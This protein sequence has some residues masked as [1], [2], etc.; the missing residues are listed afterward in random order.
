[1]KN[2]S[3]GKSLLVLLI[4]ATLTHCLDA[5][6]QACQPSGKI[7]GIK[8][9]PGQ[10][11]PENDSDCCKQGKMYTTYK[12]SPP[13]TGNT[14][15]VLTLNSFQKGGDGGGP[16]ECDNQYHSDDTPVVALSTGWYSGGD[17]CL[18][19]ITVSA[20]G[21][22]VKAKVV[23]EC[24]STMGCDDEHDYQ[25]PC[26]NNI[27]DASKA[28]WEALER[29][30]AYVREGNEQVLEAAE[31]VIRNKQDS[32]SQLQAAV[33][34]VVLDRFGIAAGGDGGGPSEYDNQYHSDDTP[35]VALSTGWYSGGD[36]CLN[37]ITV[38][39][40]G[41]SV[42]AKVVDECDSTMGCDDEY[43][44]Q[45]PCPNNI[46]DA[47]KAVW[48]A[49]G[50]PEVGASQ[51]PHN[52][53]VKTKQDKNKNHEENSIV[54][55]SLRV[56][57]VFVTLTYC[58]DARLQAC[59]PSGKIRG[60]K[61]P[62]GQCNPENDSDCCKQEKMYTT[63]K[64][65][66]P[67][68]SNTKAVLTLNSFQAGGDGG[69][70]SEC[71]NQYHS[72]DTP[73]VAHSTGWYSGGDRCL[74]YITASADGRSVKAKVVDECDSTMGCDDEHD[75]QPPCP[76]NIVDA[77]K[78]VWEALHIPEVRRW[79][80]LL[81]LRTTCLQNFVTEVCQPS[82]KIRGIKPPPG[83]CN[84]ENDSDCCKQ[85]KM[86][87]TYQCSPPVTGNTKAVLTLNSF[88]KGGDGGGPSECDKHYHSDEKPVVA[89]STGWY[90]RGDRCHNYIT[91]NANGRSVQAM[92]VD[93][94]DSTAGC[95]EVHDYQPPCPHNIVDASKAVWKAL[96][97]SEGDWGEYDITWSD[98]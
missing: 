98:A 77:S 24:D 92:V 40:N 94:C 61:P 11:N 39:A 54:G 12:C 76:N 28:V 50:I 80:G 64:C 8:P 41:R 34:F 69:G 1:M 17:R 23:D 21:R 14:K 70:P 78:A 27:V 58:L 3:L 57:L 86:Y 90:S 67:V 56:L 68:T 18:N 73:V 75:Y 72:D 38:S 37:N 60:I 96:G 25:P 30:D 13:V 36:R 46:V 19:Y 71:D 79:S 88:E 84:T 42:K 44:Y 53:Q 16:S 4:F 95:D 7:R 5:R 66:P 33:V 59:Q 89:L 62:P 20:N 91:I 47:S 81:D 49:L 35:V 97:I 45:L 85:G 65:S 43:D 55:T 9:P 93:E 63:Y 48:E 31:S 87:T 29:L 32:S 6:L 2:S 51:S 10:C 52:Q 83:Q 22:S 74:N 82:G 15:A 26:P